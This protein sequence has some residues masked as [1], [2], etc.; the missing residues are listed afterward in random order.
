MQKLKE[1]IKKATRHD[2]KYIFSYNLSPC[3]FV[4]YGTGNRTY[5][6]K[7]TDLEL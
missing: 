1:A 3:G 7:V 6:V 2:L 5:S 4:D